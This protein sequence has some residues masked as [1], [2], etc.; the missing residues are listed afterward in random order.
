VDPLHR[1]DLSRGPRSG[2]SLRAS[3]EVSSVR[4]AWA[5]SDAVAVAVWAALIL[6]GVVIGARLVD[7]GVDVL[8]GIPPLQG[9]WL[10]HATASSLVAIALAVVVTAYGPALADR[11]PWQRL[12]LAVYGTA[13]AWTVALTLV[14]GVGRGFTERLTGPSEYVL[15]AR[16]ITQSTELLDGFVA[17][18]PLD[19]VDNWPTHVA[20]HPP[21]ALAVFVALDRIGL[22]GGMWASLLAVVVGSSAAVALLVTIKALAGEAAARRVAPFAVLTPAAIW[23]GVSADA[24]WLGASAW[25]IALLALSASSRRSSQQAWLGVGAG[26][27]LGFSLYLSYG[28]VLM[29]PVAVA[30]LVEARTA[31]PALYAAAGAIAVIVGVS[32]AGFWWLDGYAAVVDRYAAG[33]GGRRPQSYWWWA[34]LAALAVVLG[35]A[36]AV[37]IGRLRREHRAVALLVAG[38]ALAVVI[39]TVGGLSKG[40]VERIWLPFA[41][42]FVPA[43]AAIPLA[44]ARRWL[45]VQAAM[46]LLLQHVLLTPW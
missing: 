6:T 28:L 11:L 10:V 16:E 23:I 13:V 15:A 46:T 45:A 5:W 24:L 20:G 38:A 2:E 21:G 19:A 40:E 22:S 9:E 34:N 3:V 31:R 4:R 32:V 1:P 33:F 35:P 8:A 29:A 7:D 36:V 14:D 27:L 37:G 42:W 26:V 41:L 44:V 18:I 12:M 39:A 30:V 17:R 43:T 25:G